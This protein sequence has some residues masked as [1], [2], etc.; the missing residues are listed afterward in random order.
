M[1]IFGFE[2]GQT[3]SSDYK[4]NIYIDITDVWEEKTA[5]MKCVITM[6]GTPDTHIRVNTH[7]GWQGKNNGR[8]RTS[9]TVSRSAP[10][11]RWSLTASLCKSV[12][13]WTVGRAVRV[14]CRLSCL[15]LPRR[16]A[17][18]GTC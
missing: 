7:R 4:P 15:N 16:A 13:Y 18:A 6:K 11:G 5:A 1:L 8:V 3:E 9:S 10:I 12:S 17:S 14:L 2:P